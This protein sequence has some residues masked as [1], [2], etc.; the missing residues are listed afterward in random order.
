MQ[1]LKEYFDKNKTVSQIKNWYQDRYETVLIQRNFL[2]VLVGILFISLGLAIDAA[3]E[4]NATKVYE[5]YIIQ[6]E[7]S[8]GIVTKVDSKSVEKY[9][10]DDVIRDSFIAKYIKAREGY[11]YGSYN[12]DYYTIT[13]LLSSQSVYEEF[14]NIIAATNK[15]SP[16]LLEKRNTIEVDINLITKLTDLG[17]I[18]VNITKNY[19]ELPS[20]KLSQSKDFVINLTYDYRD[21]DLNTN[22]RY[23]N[24]LGFQIQSY[25]IEEVNNAKSR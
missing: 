16:I 5:P 8:T 17:L 24:P 13:R 4:L 12:F 3:I 25:K 14:R 6:V 7:E 21:L 15:D 10:A 11:N 19:Y 18:Q 1:K 22:E 23:T 2:L 20:N 9:K